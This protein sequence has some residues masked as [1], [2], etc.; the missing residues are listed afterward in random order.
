MEEN[1]SAAE[2]CKTYPVAGIYVLDLRL[3]PQ[4]KIAWLERGI[5]ASR[6]SKDKGLEG[7]HLGNLG[8]A[9]A[10]LGDSKKAIEYHEQALAI[11]REIGDRRGEGNALGNLGLAYAALGDAKRPSS[12]T[13]SN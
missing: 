12:T 6:R 9:Y 11:A 1:S 5:E 4:E 2:L 13:N 7:V 8:L 10:A 3:H